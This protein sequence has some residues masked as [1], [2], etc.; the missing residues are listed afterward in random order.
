VWLLSVFA[1]VWYVDREI[2]HNFDNE[3]A[4]ISHRHVRLGHRSELEKLQHPAR[5]PRRSHLIASQAA[6]Q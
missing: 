1:V 6:V 2:N 5:R 3:L 4:E